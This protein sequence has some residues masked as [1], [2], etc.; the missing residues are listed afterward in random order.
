MT[1]VQTFFKTYPEIQNAIYNFLYR[2]TVLPTCIFSGLIDS[3]TLSLFKDCDMKWL[4]VNSPFVSPEI[5]QQD[6]DG[7]RLGMDGFFRGITLN[8]VHYPL[9]LVS[10][11]FGA[12]ISFIY[13]CILSPIIDIFS[14][15][16]QREDLRP[17]R[18]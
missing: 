3:V 15:S 11:L 17:S 13:A 14:S 2:F 16:T 5:R 4:T 12:I 6:M 9:F 1:V 10:H 7:S 18:S 8:I